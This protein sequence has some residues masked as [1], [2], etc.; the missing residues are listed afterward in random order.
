MYLAAL[1]LDTTMPDEEADDAV[2]DDVDDDVVAFRSMQLCRRFC[3]C[4][5][6]PGV[7]CAGNRWRDSAANESSSKSWPSRK[8][9]SSLWVVFRAS[10]DSAFR[11]DGFG[12][13]DGGLDSDGESDARVGFGGTGGGRTGFRGESRRLE[14]EL[15][16]GFVEIWPSRVRAATSKAEPADRGFILA[17]VST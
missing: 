15:E 5:G 12:G 6:R 9:L 11:A 8:R 10:V 2:D 1:R 4:G 14:V 16:N 13:T 3:C 7:R 17:L